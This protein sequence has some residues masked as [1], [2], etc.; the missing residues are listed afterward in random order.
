MV[1]TAGGAG[2]GMSLRDLFRGK[3]SGA[4]ARAGPGRNRIS[5]CRYFR[6]TNCGAVYDKDAVVSGWRAAPI[7]LRRYHS[8]TRVSNLQVR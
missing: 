6:C 3:R 1:P 5:R 7:L 8:R 2:N 4:D